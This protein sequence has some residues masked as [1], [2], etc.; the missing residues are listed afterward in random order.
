MFIIL[1]YDENKNFYECPFCRFNKII[2]DYIYCPICG[3]RIQF[4]K[5]GKPYK[6]RREVYE[7][8]K[9]IYGIDVT[10]DFIR[11]NQIPEKMRKYFK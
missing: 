2:K 7:I 4:K 3:K 10:D 9:K 1:D 6:P 11:R 5:E 8:Y